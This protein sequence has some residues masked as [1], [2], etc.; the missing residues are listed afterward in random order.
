[1]KRALLKLERQTLDELSRP[2]PGD[3]THPGSARRPRGPTR[4][5]AVLKD[6]ILYA[7]PEVGEDGK[8]L[9]GLVGYLTKIAREDPKTYASLLARV[10]PLQV[11]STTTTEVTYRSIDEVKAEL[12]ARGILVDRI[13]H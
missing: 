12:A 8:G 11:N 2:L 13:Y 5:T 1:M 7:A 6:A 9:N 4:V 3:E 10:I